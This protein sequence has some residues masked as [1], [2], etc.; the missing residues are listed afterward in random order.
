MLLLAL[1]AC[2]S[3]V[4]D[5]G[6]IDPPDWPEGT[7]AFV[8][9][10]VLTMVGDEVLA[11]HIVA[12]HEGAILDV[13]PPGPLPE[14]VEVLGEGGFLMPG[15]VD[16][17]VHTWFETDLT[18]YAANG[19]TSIRNLF[20]DPVHLDWRADI[21]AG[22]RFG[23]TIYTTGPIIDGSPPIWTGSDVLTDPAD[24]AGI[25]ADQVA[26]GYDAVKVYAKLDEASW[27]AVL[28]EA[29][30]A[31]VPAYGHV[32]WSTDY[33]TVLA[34]TQLTIEHLDGFLEA[35]AGMDGRLG[36]DLYDPTALGAAIDQVDESRVLDLAA[37]HADT[38]CSPTITVYRRLGNPGSATD[39]EAQLVDPAWVDSWETQE[40]GISQKVA[41][42]AYADVM[43]GFVATLEANG[44]P[45][46]L[47]TDAG[48]PWVYPGFALHEELAEFVSAGVDPHA[49]LRAG[50]ANAAAALRDDSFGTV[51]AGKRADLLWLA[52]DPRQL[53]IEPSGVM[54]RGEWF[55][56]DELTAMLELL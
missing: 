27:L 33:A 34:S 30:T 46:V 15:L 5:T 3:E 25:V 9:V 12:V 28:A 21:Q 29:D 53:P 56:A 8:D 39:P 19:V 23:P 1:L 17:H 26:A 14:H 55:T 16:M 13:V 31:G 49:A 41:M 6:S 37:A 18:L 43:A 2:T 38:Y 7:V 10:D 52:S 35:A 40:L 24:A 51:E 4:L 48:N 20:G 44:T 54:L 50:T 36:Y 11:G 47:G 22:E 42:D 45:M 32:P